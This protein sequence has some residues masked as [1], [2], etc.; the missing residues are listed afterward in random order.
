[1]S[2]GLAAAPWYA[3]MF[4]FLVGQGG[5]VAAQIL[6][7]KQGGGVWVTLGIA[8]MQLI[9]AVSAAYGP[10]AAGRL[11]R[12]VGGAIRAGRGSKDEGSVEEDGSPPDAPR[13][14]S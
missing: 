4:M 3:I 1:M 10:G 12:S 13:V 6:A 9:A 7:Y 8:A 2:N 14:G 11:A 5:L